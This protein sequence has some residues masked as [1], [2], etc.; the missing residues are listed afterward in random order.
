MSQLGKNFKN[1][2]LVLKNQIIKITLKDTRFTLKP[3]KK[4]SQSGSTA[5]PRE[6]REKDKSVKKIPKQEAEN[7]SNR[8]L[9]LRIYKSIQRQK[10]ST[11]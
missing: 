7:K 5:A 4:S 11:V 6:S 10:K 8:L 3:Q 2:D 9:T 1:K